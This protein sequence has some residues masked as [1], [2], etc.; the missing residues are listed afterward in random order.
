MLTPTIH[1]TTPPT[2]GQ[3]T[4]LTGRLSTRLRVA[5]YQQS[6][7]GHSLVRKVALHPATDSMLPGTGQVRDGQTLNLGE[8]WQG[9]IPGCL[10][11]CHTVHRGQVIRAAHGAPFLPTPEGGGLLAQS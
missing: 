11:C 9:T 8:S 10:T 7:I 5:R 1:N 6:T 4:P 3:L 2:I